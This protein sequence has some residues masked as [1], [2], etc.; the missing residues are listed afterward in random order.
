MMTLARWVEHAFDVAVDRLH[1]TDAR[2]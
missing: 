2:E 1:D